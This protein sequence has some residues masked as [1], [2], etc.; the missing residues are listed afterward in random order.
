MT[1][2]TGMAQLIPAQI[3]RALGQPL[4]ITLLSSIATANI[5]RAQTG[6]A[7]LIYNMSRNLGG[8]IGIAAM[9]TLLTVQEQFHSERLT[10]N[11]SL[12]LTATQ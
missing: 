10:D 11:I 1:H 3:V 8:S 4:V 5:E 2:D 7:S 12:Y 9:S 6:S